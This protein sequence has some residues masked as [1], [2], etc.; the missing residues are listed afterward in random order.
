MANH[1]VMVE[2][3]GENK[4]HALATETQAI[5]RTLRIGQTRQVTVTYFLMEAAPQP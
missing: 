3:P 5:G 1:V 2:P 4:A